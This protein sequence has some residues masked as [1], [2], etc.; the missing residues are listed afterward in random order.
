MD[1]N[2]L[3]TAL[4]NLE[5]RLTE[6][7]DNVLFIESKN[8]RFKEIENDLSKEHVWSD[9]KLFQ[10]LSKEKTN[11]EKVLSSFNEVSHLGQK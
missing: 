2:E 10:K 11:I 4:L 8:K 5:S 1:A 6:I 7:K 9:L 3:K